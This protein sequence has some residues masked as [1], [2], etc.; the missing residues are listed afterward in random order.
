VGQTAI[1]R[2]FAGSSQSETW[3]CNQA[4]P[5]TFLDDFLAPRFRR[6]YLYLQKQYETISLWSGFERRLQGEFLQ[7]ALIISRSPQTCCAFGLI[8]QLIRHA[9]FELPAVLPARW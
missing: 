9:P 6:A 4:D 3:S 1:V 8:Y 2:S 7:F 5:L